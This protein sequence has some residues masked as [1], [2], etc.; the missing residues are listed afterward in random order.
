VPDQQ[1][2][3]QSNRTIVDIIDEEN[4]ALDNF[5]VIFF[6]P[7]P[8]R[9]AVRVV[10]DDGLVKLTLNRDKFL[11][12]LAGLIDLNKEHV[13]YT[14]AR[15]KEALC[16][17]GGFYVYDRV[18]DEFYEL[19]ERPNFE[20]FSPYDLLEYSRAGLKPN[21]VETNH[22]EL[23]A[24]NEALKDRFK[25]SFAPIVNVYNRMSTVIRQIPKGVKKRH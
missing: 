14:Y 25:P 11:S 10:L 7:Q 2:L 23:I 8:H 21:P 16:R 15:V 3:P 9:D 22:K 18:K 1:P 5:M 6:E 13:R 4:R 19:Q 17:Y 24:R 12:I 20:K